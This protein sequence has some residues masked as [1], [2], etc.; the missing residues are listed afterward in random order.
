MTGLKALAYK[1]R[2][3]SQCG[4]QQALIEHI[5]AESACEYSVRRVARA[6][7]HNVALRLFKPERESGEA[8]GDEIYKQQVRRF[9]N[10][11][12]EE[13]RRKYR[14]HFREV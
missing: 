7:A 11:E 4:D 2:C 1:E 5:K 10:R 9:E 8:V 12:A 13:R 3:E 14:E 6:A